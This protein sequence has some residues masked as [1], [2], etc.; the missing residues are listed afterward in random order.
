MKWSVKREWRPSQRWIDGVL[1]VGE[2]LS[3]ACTSRC[4]GDRGVDQ[5]EEAAE[6]FGA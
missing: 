5:V 6:L 1:W 4:A 3:T 2:L